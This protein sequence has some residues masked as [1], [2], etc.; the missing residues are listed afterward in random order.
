MYAPPVVKPKTRPAP[1][2][3]N[4][5][6]LQ[7]SSVVEHRSSGGPFEQAKLLQRTIG[8]Q[9]VLR[10]LAQRGGVTRNEPGAQEKEADSAHTV[11]QEAAPSWDF[12]KIPIFSPCHA[13]RFQMPPAPRLPIQAKL[14]VGAVNDPLEREADRVAEALLAAPAHPVVRATPARPSQPVTDLTSVDQS[15]TGPGKSL[16][17]ALQEEMEHRFGH[18]FSQVRVH[19][20]AAAEHSARGLNANAYTVGHN[21]VFGTGR[22][23]PSTLE[24]RRLLAHELTHVVQQWGADGGHSNK[25][26]GALPISKRAIAIQRDTPEHP[27]EQPGRNRKTVGGGTGS[28]ALSKGVIIWGMSYES[29]GQA[30]VA[31]VQIIFSPYKSYRGKNIT[32]LQTVLRTRSK[33]ADPTKRAS[34]DILTLGR[35]GAHRDETDPFYGEDWD[36]KS[37][38]WQAEGAPSGF[39]NQPGG[40]SDPNAY[41]YDE[42]FVY[43]GQLKMFET[44][45]VLPETTE[46]LGTI[47]WGVQGSDDGVKVLVP[48]KDKDVSDAPTAGFLVALD[49]F[50]NQPSTVGPDRDREERYDA[51]LDNFAANDGTSAQKAALLTADQQ[52]KLDP[53]VAKVMGDP[54]LEVEVG[55]FADATEKDPSSTSEARARAVESYL[56][57]KG[58]PKGNV[59]M[60]GFFGAAWARYPPSPTESRN[61]RVQVRVRMPAQ[62]PPTR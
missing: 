60:A 39:R 59:V 56:V 47:I 16:E 14:K 57:A 41:L 53:I 35:E 22:F 10:L 54:T 44:V 20:G 46:T 37:R 43:P 6:T 8:N 45:A 23:A 40:A 11:A 32:F 61:R 30:T 1:S 5:L 9:A 27:E 15:L 33:D 36:N 2:S 25:P 21:I 42:P 4:K 3:N 58:V 52:K 17:P 34:I 62:Q 13:E 24:G 18:D 48:D 19:S 12:S 49:R 7:R 26:R 29:R 38:T 28:K 50:Y 51:I 31:V 55:G